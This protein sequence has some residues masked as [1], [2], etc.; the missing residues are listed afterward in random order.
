MCEKDFNSLVNAEF[1]ADYERRFAEI[2][3]AEQNAV[4]ACA[5]LDAQC[6]REIA[7]IDRQ[8]QE[9]KLAAEQTLASIEERSNAQFAGAENR[10][11]ADEAEY[12]KKI[13]SAQRTFNKGT[14]ECEN[15]R[16]KLHQD[17]NKTKA[18]IEK[19][20]KA[21]LFN[22]DKRFK[23]VIKK[24]EKDFKTQADNYTRR[25]DDLRDFGTAQVLQ[26]QRRKQPCGLKQSKRQMQ[27]AD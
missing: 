1:L 21:D 19:K 8:H 2:G 11:A 6:E 7:E 5:E 4:D 17:D 23:E 27:R 25:L 22:E 13:R 24:R 14:K 16:T 18:D 9:F 12:E 15:K 3:Q 26:K 20:Y 10:Y